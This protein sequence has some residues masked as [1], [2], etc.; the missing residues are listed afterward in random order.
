MILSKVQKWGWT[1][2]KYI[3]RIVEVFHNPWR[4]LLLNHLHLLFQGIRHNLRAAGP[5]TLL[6]PIHTIVFILQKIK[7]IQRTSK[8]LDVPRLEVSQQRWSEDPGT[9][10]KYISPLVFLHRALVFDQ[11]ITAQN[12]AG[13]WLLIQHGPARKLDECEP[14][15][16]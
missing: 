7:T 2:V 15:N 3:F 10:V 11:F 1:P 13:T 12:E 5:L 6:K 9:A 14:R 8:T 16:N 4:I